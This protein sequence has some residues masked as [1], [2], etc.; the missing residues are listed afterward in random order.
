MPTKINPE[1]IIDGE[2]E[3]VV[4]TLP[5]TWEDDEDTYEDHAEPGEQ[6]EIVNCIEIVRDE[7]EPEEPG[8]IND[9]HELQEHPDDH[10]DDA[11]H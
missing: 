10:A 2:F 3:D 5:D 6:R 1:D 7:P 11:E 4:D 9:D 8:K